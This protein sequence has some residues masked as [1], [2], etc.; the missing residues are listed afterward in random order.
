MNSPETP[1]TLGTQDTGEINARETEGVMKNGQS[2]N[3]GSIG[4][5]RHRTKINVR[6]TEGVIK[7]EQS[8]DTGN[9]GYT[10]HRKNKR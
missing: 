6:E 7:N 4:Y 9:I 5:T 3:T 2:R 10:R 8:R 1:V